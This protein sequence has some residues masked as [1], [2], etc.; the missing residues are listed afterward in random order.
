V[1]EL[2]IQMAAF[3]RWLLAIA[4]VIFAIRQLQS[5]WRAH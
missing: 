2:A 4:G 3:A 5:A 1:Y